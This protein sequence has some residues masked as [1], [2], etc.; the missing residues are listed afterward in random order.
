MTSLALPREEDA[1]G[2]REGSKASLLHPSTATKGK[3]KHVPPIQYHPPSRSQSVAFVTPLPDD[4]GEDEGEVQGRCHP[5][6][7]AEV[8]VFMI[9]GASG[10]WASNAITAEFPVFVKAVPEGDRFPNLVNVAFQIGNV[11]PFLYKAVTGWCMS[12][13]SRRKAISSTVFILLVFG[14]AVLLL[15]AFFWD[16]TISVDGSEYSGVLLLCSFMAGGIGTMSNVTYWAFATRYPTHCTKALSTGMT[17]GGLVLSCII[18]AQDA[19]AHPRF[20][21]TVYFLIAASL[22]IMMLVATLP[23]MFGKSK[24]SLEGAR[25]APELEPLLEEDEDDLDSGMDTPLSYGTGS[26]N[27]LPSVSPT[28]QPPWINGTGLLFC[29]LCFLIYGMTYALPSMM[30]F[31]L[32]GYDKPA[33]ELNPP[34]NGTHHGTTADYSYGELYEPRYFMLMDGGGGAGSQLSKPVLS[35]T[36]VVPDDSSMQSSIYK[37]AMVLQSV[38]DV[39]GRVCTAVYTPDQV[40][41]L[42]T[43]AFT[44]FL[45]FGTMTTAAAF[46]HDVATL[47]PGDNGYAISVCAFF[48]YFLR[49]Y[50]VTSMYVWVKINLK[51]EDAERLS[52][53]LGLCGQIGALLANGV[54]LLLTT[55]LGNGRAILR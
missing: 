33:H 7:V 48:Y 22:Q 1:L 55:P 28:K 11:F 19:G 10:W 38:G 5:Q 43:M 8:F 37:W 39:L 26:I 40:E 41:T 44:A 47:L 18:L 42:V 32:L 36:T 20:S 17:F 4:E 15:A 21:A 53:N 51:Q 13:E 31:V 46:H 2:E 24:A 27:A 14:C 29:V 52:E 16:S 49:G 50:T 3:G 23:F 45:L 6:V 9:F 25:K 35:N 12:A 34:Q 54:M 30:P